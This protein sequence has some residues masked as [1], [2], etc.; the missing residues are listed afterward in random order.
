MYDAT[1]LV[2]VYSFGYTAVLYSNMVAWTTTTTTATNEKQNENII[3]RLNL[4]H[5]GT[6]STQREQEHN[7]KCVCV[8]M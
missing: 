4:S 1:E 7:K 5:A 2:D 6:Y 3:Y 8:A